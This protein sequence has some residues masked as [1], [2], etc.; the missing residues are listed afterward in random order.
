MYTKCD[1]QF[2]PRLKVVF[3]VLTSLPMFEY[4]GSINVREAPG[5]FQMLEAIVKRNINTIKDLGR[6]CH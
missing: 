1:S 3:L 6:L 5:V 4:G 2:C